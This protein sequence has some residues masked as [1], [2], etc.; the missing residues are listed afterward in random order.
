MRVTTGQIALA[1]LNLLLA[2]AL[3]LALYSVLKAAD[4]APTEQPQPAPESPMPEVETRLP[5]QQQSERL[6]A[7]LLQRDDLIPFEGILGGTM[8]FYTPD[9]VYVLSERWVYAR[10]EDGHIGGEM[11]LEYR[12]DAAGQIDWTVLRAELD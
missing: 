3:A 7:D 10:F 2:L 9:N 4:A 12:F 8:G 6:V 1:A 5:P 11:L